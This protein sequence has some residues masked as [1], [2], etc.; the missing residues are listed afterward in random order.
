MRSSTYLGGWSATPGPI[1]MGSAFSR[2]SEHRSTRRQGQ[3][4]PHWRIA[5]PGICKSICRLARKIGVIPRSRSGR[6]LPRSP[7]IGVHRPA[8]RKMPAAAAIRFC[9]TVIGSGVSP[10]DWRP[11]S[12]SVAIPMP[13]RSSSRPKPGQPSGKVE[14]RRCRAHPNSMVR[15][16]RRHSTPSKGVFG[17]LLSKDI[18]PP[19]DR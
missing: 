17:I 3:A 13:R 10:K 14:N 2:T 7:M 11:Q 18:V 9:A 19:T 15:N 6:G 12:R 4:S 16:S 5:Q 1:A 8:S